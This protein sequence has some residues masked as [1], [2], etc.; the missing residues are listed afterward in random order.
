MRTLRVVVVLGLVLL[1]ACRSRAALASATLGAT[2]VTAGVALTYASD[3]PERHT[4]A[5]VQFGLAAYFLAVA[6]LANHVHSEPADL[7]LLAAHPDTPASPSWTGADGATGVA[8]DGATGIATDRAAGG[9]PAPTGPTAPAA[10]AAPARRGAN[11]YDHTGAYAGRIDAQG[12]L[13]DRTGAY[14]G[15]V[16]ERES[17]Y[18]HTGAYAGRVDDRGEVFD[19]TGAYAGRVDAQ[20]QLYDRTGAVTGRLDANGNVYDH[21]GAF[22]GRVD[23]SCD[24]ACRRTAAAQI[25]LRR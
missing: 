1:S 6:A 7:P 20:G 16:D 14:A 17:F 4:V 12:N 21:T 9:G 13:Y 8:I 23:G 5:Y 18:D 11:A 2:F 19:P 15:R 24:E 10:R 3:E 22:A 25:L